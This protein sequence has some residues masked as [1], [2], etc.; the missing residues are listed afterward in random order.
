MLRLLI[1]KVAR[2][3]APNGKTASVI[4]K[5]EQQ[6]D[7]LAQ[8]RYDCTQ[9]LTTKERNSYPERW[10]DRPCETSPTTAE[11]AAARKLLPSS[12]GMVAIPAVQFWKMR[13]IR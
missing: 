7:N 11:K 3:A 1:G 12:F 9:S 4:P 8:V 6:L 10:R 5:P 2:R 13:G